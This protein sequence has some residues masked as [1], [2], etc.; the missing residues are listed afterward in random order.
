MRRRPAAAPTRDEPLELAYDAAKAVLTN[1]DAT[2]GNLRTRASG[3]L[4]VATLLT[5]FTVALGLLTTDPAKGAVLPRWAAWSL[6]AILVAVGA[7]VLRI[8]WPVKTWH[9]G[10]HPVVI[11]DK[12]RQGRSI[13]DIREHVTEK[14]IAGVDANRTALRSRQAAFRWSVVL[15]LVEVVLLIAGLITVA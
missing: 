7:L 6:L 9:F 10:P 11:M 8:L 13:V 5:S 14:M 15:L 12:R 4:T 3:L 1:Q 2:L